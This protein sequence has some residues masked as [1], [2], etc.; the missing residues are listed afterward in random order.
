[1][2][3]QPRPTN[4]RRRAI[5][6]ALCFSPLVL[7]LCS[8]FV[9]LAGNERRP[10][11]AI[12][13][14]VAALFFAIVNFHLSFFRP[15]WLRRRHGLEAIP[16]VSGLPIVGTVLVLLGGT[17][18]FGAIGTALFGLVAV[19]LDTG[20]APWFLIATWRDS[21]LWDSRK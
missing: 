5:G 1:M 19:A 16:H 11:S 14:V 8:V 18:G 3:E 2:S 10:F 21:S 15:W 12:G 6:L 7:L 9:A 13:F 20:G 4:Y 17:L